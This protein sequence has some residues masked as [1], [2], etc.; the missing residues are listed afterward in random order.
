MSGGIEYQNFSKKYPGE[1][2]NSNNIAP[3]IRAGIEF[4]N[5][6]WQQSLSGLLSF[7][8]SQMEC[9][10]VSSQDYLRDYYFAASKIGSDLSFRYTYPKGRVRP[11]A[12]IGVNLFDYKFSSEYDFWVSVDTPPRYIR[13]TGKVGILNVWENCQ[14]GVG[15]NILVRKE[16]FVFFNLRYKID[17][18]AEFT[19]FGGLDNTYMSVK[20]P[21]NN[22]FLFEIGYRF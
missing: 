11:H 21:Y 3:L 10:F 8:F 20:A 9:N 4:S 16:Q 5:P 2:L 14:I 13:N 7:Y 22:V 15:V 17:L 1:R 19:T 12:E 18:S 6:R